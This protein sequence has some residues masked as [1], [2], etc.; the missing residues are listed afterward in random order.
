MRT[1]QEIEEKILRKYEGRTSQEAREILYR[2]VR[3][4]PDYNGPTGAIFDGNIL[5]P[6]AYMVVT[7]LGL[8]LIAPAAM[9]SL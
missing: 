4:K 6:L 1:A 3:D 2:E 9:A 7:E 5:L 8:S